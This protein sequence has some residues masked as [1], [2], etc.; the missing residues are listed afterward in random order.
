MGGDSAGGALAAA[1]TL[2]SR[3]EG[4]LDIC[5]QMLIYPVLD[6]RM[7][8]ES[9]KKYTDSPV[10]NAPLS[11]K[12][13]KLYL[14]NGTFGKRYYASPAEAEDFHDLPP[15]YIEVEQYDCLHDEGVDYWR[16]LKKTGITV[17]LQDVKGTFHGFDV[18]TETE[19]TKKMLEIRC[20]AL[21]RALRNT[22]KGKGE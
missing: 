8:T 19:I 5:F 20:R 6:A 7:K 1:C 13:W 2:R 10:W 9:M 15:A 3:D 14:K 12:M 21:H 17:E 11:R 16:N 18:F 4:K 22:M